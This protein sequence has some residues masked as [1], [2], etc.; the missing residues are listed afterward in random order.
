MATLIYKWLMLFWLLPGTAQEQAKEVHPFHV[1]TT[2]IQHNAAEKT[3]EISCRIF[4]DD[5]E[6]ALRKVYKA[7]ADFSAPAMKT[8]MDELVKKYIPTHLQLSIDGK[9]AAIKVLGWEKES[10]AVFVYME[11]DN[12]PSVK[13]AEVVNTVLFDLFDDQM[14]LIHFFVN[15]NRKS[16]KLTY[17]EKTAAFAF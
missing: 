3:L 12:V 13:K 10:E 15:G 8:A 11:V 1:S 5:F 14:N 7:K 6:D 17:P 9:A 2:E 4:T 16:M